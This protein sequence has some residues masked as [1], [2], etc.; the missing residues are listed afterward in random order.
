MKSLLVYTLLLTWII[1]P[2]DRLTKIS[3]AS[4]M[5]QEIDIVNDSIYLDSLA[6]HVMTDIITPL[7]VEVT[8]EYCE[9]D[10]AIYHSLL[11]S[12]VNHESKKKIQ[13]AFMLGV[14]DIDLAFTGIYDRRR[15]SLQYLD[16]VIKLS[17]LVDIEGLYD[18]EHLK[19]RAESGASVEE[20][21]RVR[22][23]NFQVMTR[24]FRKMG[25]GHLILHYLV[26]SWLET[27]YV[28][29]YYQG[30]CPNSDL[31]RRIKEQA[32]SF[33]QLLE[34]L[35]KRQP[36]S[37]LLSLCSK[38]LY[39]ILDKMN[40]QTITRKDISILKVSLFKVRNK[41]CLD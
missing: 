14:Y 16:A 34:I 29:T 18:Y 20:D 13:Q 10:T 15:L 35:K 40:R 3:F 23:K 9:E 30:N 37:T 17:E 39:P 7:W 22:Y 12:N 26:G 31:K 4:T 8:L 24:H 5:S 32:G 2:S 19:E 25:K 21:Q 6:N 33:L 41:M 11:S 38:H 36:T 27:M 1:N 28:A